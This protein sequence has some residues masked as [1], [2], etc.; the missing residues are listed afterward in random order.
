MPE[1][2]LENPGA[3][4][5]ETITPTP[6]DAEVARESVRELAS[7]TRRQ[8]NPAKGSGAVK[9]RLFDD[10]QSI[11]V[12]IPASALRVLASML[13]EMSRGN[14]VTFIPTH[15][16]LTTQQAADALNVSRPFLIGLLEKGEIEFK[17]VGRHRRVRFSALMDYKHKTDISRRQAIVDLMREGEDLAMGD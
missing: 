13:A 12:T 17:K 6:Q 2:L 9:V 3:E 16:E 11:D 4:F 14:T 15:A 1:S 8:P 10:G 5:P 7:F